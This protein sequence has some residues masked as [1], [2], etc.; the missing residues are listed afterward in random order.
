M[1]TWMGGGSV[2]RCTAHLFLQHVLQFHGKHP[3]CCLAINHNPGLSLHSICIYSMYNVV[4]PYS[5]C[6]LSESPAHSHVLHGVFLSLF[7]VLSLEQ[8]ERETERE[9]EGGWVGG[10]EGRRKHGL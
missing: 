5:A 3:S 2:V 1:H 6:R 10:R 4:V 7:L 8:R 9:R